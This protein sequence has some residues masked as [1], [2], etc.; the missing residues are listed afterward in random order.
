MY[1]R[2][3]DQP[4]GVPPNIEDDNA[5]ANVWTNDSGS[6]EFS[7]GI[8]DEDQAQKSLGTK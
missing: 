7:E 1:Q 2:L 3:K 5:S 6:D 8:S 4:L